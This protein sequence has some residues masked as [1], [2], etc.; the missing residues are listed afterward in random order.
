MNKKIKDSQKDERSIRREFS[1][2]KSLVNTE[3]EYKSE[4]GKILRRIQKERVSEMWTVGKE[5][6]KKYIRDMEKQYGSKK[7]KV[8]KYR[9]INVGDEYLK[10][11]FETEVRIYG[12][13]EMS[14]EAK[15]FNIQR[16]KN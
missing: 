12:N 1:N 6:N 3:V 13:I 7:V 8:T 11:K 14:E 15:D 16:N 4:E 5:R 9:D 10:E 2:I